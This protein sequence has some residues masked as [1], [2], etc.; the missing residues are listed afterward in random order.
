MTAIYKV[1]YLTWKQFDIRRYERLNIKLVEAIEDLDKWRD[2]YNEWR[3]NYGRETVRGEIDTDYPIIENRHARIEPVRRALPLINLGLVSSAGFYLDGTE[4]FDTTS[5]EGDLSFREI[6]SIVEAADL[7]LAGRG[8]DER[9]AREDINAQL[10]LNRLH[11]FSAN[12]IIGSLAEVFFSFNGYITNVAPFVEQTLPQLVARIKRYPVQAVM[13]IPASRLCH[14][15]CTLAARAIEAAGVP[16]MTLGIEREIFDTVR[17]PRAVYYKGE[18]GSVVG[19]AN[20][21]EFQRRVLD[22]ALRAME[23]WDQPG[24]RHLNV[25]IE[26]AVEHSRGER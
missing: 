13:L 5:D 17:V 15:S 14:Q 8:Y 2:R 6:P 7:Q 25:E 9:A 26:T 1:C 22:E 3:G 24:V 18:S 4:A 11:E 10:P 21:K 23:S 19:A 20:F 16:T 12:G